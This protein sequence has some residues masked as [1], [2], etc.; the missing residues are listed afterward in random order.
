MRA[1]RARI[2]IRRS[3]SETLPRTRRRRRGRLH[4]TT[5]GNMMYYLRVVSKHL[6]ATGLSSI[7]NFPEPLVVATYNF[8]TDNFIQCVFAFLFD[9][10]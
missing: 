2:S 1:Q 8:Q 3:P 6:E 9:V 5:T 4:L 10:R 7:E